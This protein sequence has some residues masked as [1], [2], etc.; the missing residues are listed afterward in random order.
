VLQVIPKSSNPKRIKENLDIFTLDSD[1][2]EKLDGINK[3]LRYNDAS[4]VFG[5]PFFSNEKDAELVKKQMVEQ[6]VKA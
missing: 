2:L 1:D 4:E 5:Y 3:N 6:T